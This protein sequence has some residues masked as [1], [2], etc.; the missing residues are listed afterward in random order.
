[1]SEGKYTLDGSITRF[2]LCFAAD[3]QAVWL[4]AAHVTD[5][6]MMLGGSL[7]PTICYFIKKEQS[8]R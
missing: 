3:R 8:Q 4:S 2:A 6:S 5:Q 7:Q 1:M